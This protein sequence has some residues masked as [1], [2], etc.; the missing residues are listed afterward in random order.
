MPSPPRI[1]VK[2]SARTLSET[3]GRVP[4]GPTR[5]G[6][7][8]CGPAPCWIV[9]PLRG[10]TALHRAKPCP[11]ICWSPAVGPG[12]HLVVIGDV[13]WGVREKVGASGPESHL[14]ER[15]RRQHPAQQFQTAAFG[16]EVRAG[17]PDRC[18]G[19]TS[20]SAWP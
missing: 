2:C 8:V 9:V 4:P 12:W 10:E 13:L 6:E 15:G 11:L 7:I 18:T 19:C 16:A 1:M 3:Y 5:S 14:R 20:P 17:R